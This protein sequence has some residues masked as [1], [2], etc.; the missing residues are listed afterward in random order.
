MAGGS[1]EGKRARKYYMFLVKKRRDPKLCSVSKMGK[2][3]RLLKL[4]SKG[5]QKH[6]RFAG[7]TDES[8]TSC[9]H[10]LTRGGGG[11]GGN[12]GTIWLKYRIG[13]RL[14]QDI[15]MGT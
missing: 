11:R 10:R 15:V 1:G 7:R 14:R 9:S 8:H 13:A 4:S 6:D 3:S 12:G 5:A 2:K